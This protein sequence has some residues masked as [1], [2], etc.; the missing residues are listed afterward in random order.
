MSQDLTVATERGEQYPVL[1]ARGAAGR[2]AELLPGDC[3]AVALISDDNV[4]RI[5]GDR[6]ADLLGARAPVVRLGFPAGEQH[7][8]RG[9]KAQLEDA[10]LEQGLGRD[11][12]VVALGGGVT[13]DLAGHVAGTYMRGVPWI[14]LPT[15]L[16]AAVDASVGGKV[17]V[18]TEAGKNLIGLFHQPLGVCIDPELI[19]TLPPTEVDNG[20]AEMAK[21]A[22][23][24]DGGYLEQ[25]VARTDAVRA[26]DAQTLLDAIRRSV[27]IKARVVSADSAEQGLRQVLNLGHTIG[28]ALEV[29]SGWSLGHGLAV[30][31]GIS[32]EAGIA[33][34]LGLLD[35]ESRDRIRAALDGLGLP[36]VPPIGTDPAAL[37]DATKLDKKGRRGRTRYALPAGIG[38]MAG[39]L[40]GGFAREV[41]D[42]IVLEAIAEV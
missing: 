21:H 31:I 34:R 30:S 7:K 25:L 16:L 5:H 12:V 1:L 22:I 36:V 33:H 40:E 20:L 39:A 4:G 26:L 17:G 15:S 3:T 32:V 11:C 13:N 6:V 2:V 23:I 10:M 38:A 37:L 9:V 14:P 41:P 28:H 42:R 35:R 27:Q 8:T 18:D 19:A 24:A 29:V